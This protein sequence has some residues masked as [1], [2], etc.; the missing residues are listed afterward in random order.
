MLCVR[1]MLC[2][3]VDINAMADKKQVVFSLILIT[4]CTED[5]T[6]FEF[7]KKYIFVGIP[8]FSASSDLYNTRQTCVLFVWGLSGR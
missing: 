2:L 5:Q 6:I 1:F 7:Y 3:H 8:W 4:F